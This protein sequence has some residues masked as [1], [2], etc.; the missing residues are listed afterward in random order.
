M[1]HSFIKVLF[2]DKDLSKQ[3]KYQACFEYGFDMGMNFVE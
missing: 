3:E 2:E 1:I